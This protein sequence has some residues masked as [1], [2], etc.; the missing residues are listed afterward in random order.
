MYSDPFSG[1]CSVCQNIHSPYTCDQEWFDK[2]AAVNSSG[3][4]T[5]TTGEMTMFGYMTEMDAAV[6]EVMGAFR[7][8]GKYENSFVIFSSDVSKRARHCPR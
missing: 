6:G 8:T 7:K 3:A 4:H 5:Y 1:T 2:Y